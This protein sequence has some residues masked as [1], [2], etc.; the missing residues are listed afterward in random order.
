MAVYKRTYKAYCGPLT[1]ARSRFTVLARYGFSTLFDSRLFTAYTVLCFLPF[2]VGVVFIYLMHSATA[3]AILNV[4]FGNRQ[5]IVDN[6]WFAGFLGVEMWMGFLLTAWGAPGM[7]TRDFA[8]QSIQL[9]LSRPLSRPEYLAGKVS[10]L[11]GLLSC[12]TWIPALVLFFLQAQLEGNH[13]GWNNLSIAGA[14]ILGGLLWIALISLL[15]MALAVWVRWR[16]AAT[17]LMIGFFFLLPGLGQAI[18]LILRTSWG[19]LLNFPYLTGMVFAHLFRLPLHQLE[20]AG[21]MQ[22]PL[23]SAWAA[24]LSVCVISLLLLDRRLQAREVERG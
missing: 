8:N 4:H 3:Q 21:F 22:I 18:N 15:S 16:I 10:V 17:G 2:L 5:E 6:R 13:W 12:T 11:A 1:P 19:N 7:I 24:L 20:Q 14:I 23:W 9:Y